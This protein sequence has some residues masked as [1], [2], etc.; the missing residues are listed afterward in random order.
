MSDSIN[1]HV[2]E[3]KTLDNDLED[4]NVH[5]SISQAQAHIDHVEMQVGRAEAF[6]QIVEGVDAI[7]GSLTGVLDNRGDLSYNHPLKV[8]EYDHV[9][10]GLLVGVSAAVLAGQKIHEALF[11]ST[12]ESKCAVE[13]D[14]AQEQEIVN[15]IELGGEGVENNQEQEICAHYTPD[16]SRD[17]DNEYV[18]VEEVVFNETYEKM[19]DNYLSDTQILDQGFDNDQ[20]NDAGHGH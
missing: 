10:D 18:E 9:G 20:D 12:A 8:P 3:V 5:R 16:E 11:E 19:Y 4:E 13:N 7:D 6:E 2:P 15:C 1:D 14:S 17:L